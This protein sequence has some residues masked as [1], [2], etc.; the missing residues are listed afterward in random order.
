MKIN[1]VRKVLKANDIVAEKNRE[2]FF[3]KALKQ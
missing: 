2:V 3:S 1:V